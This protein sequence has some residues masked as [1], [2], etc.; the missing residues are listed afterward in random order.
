MHSD[1]VWGCQW[2]GPP[3]L[4]DTSRI[5]CTVPLVDFPFL[6]EEQA[7]EHSEGV[8]VNW[9]DGPGDFSKK[10]HVVETGKVCPRGQ[11]D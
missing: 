3:Q 10:G 9:Q 6:D 5:S 1:C 11:Q 8:G 7:L 4:W 2:W